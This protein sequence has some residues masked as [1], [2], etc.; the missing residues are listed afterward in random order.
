MLKQEFE[1]LDPSQPRCH[2]QLAAMQGPVTSESLLGQGIWWWEAELA[3]PC[4]AM[5]VSLCPT[6]PPAPY[7]VSLA[8]FPGSLPPD[9]T[10]P[11]ST[12]YRVLRTASP[13]PDPGGSQLASPDVW[14]LPLK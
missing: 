8:Y 1:T 10:R 7:W 12:F 14:F 11:R 2:L 9:P 6:I 13:A 3:C 4:P 5:L